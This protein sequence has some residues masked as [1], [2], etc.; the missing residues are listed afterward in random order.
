MLFGPR[1]ETDTPDLKHP[2][3][4]HRGVTFICYK[5]DPQTFLCP[6]GKSQMTYYHDSLTWD[7]IHLLH[8]SNQNE[9]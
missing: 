5:I 4:F 3:L 7:T 6:G 1:Y 2:F 9:W 8:Q